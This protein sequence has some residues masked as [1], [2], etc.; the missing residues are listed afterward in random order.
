MEG[1]VMPGC[2]GVHCASAAPRAVGGVG[3]KQR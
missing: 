3:V 1:I 2:V